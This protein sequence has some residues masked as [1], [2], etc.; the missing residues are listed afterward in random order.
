V[1]PTSL[2][3]IAEQFAVD[4]KIS[5]IEKFGGGLINDTYRINT[6]SKKYAQ[7]ILQRIN[8]EVFLQPEWV[9][10]NLQVLLAHFDKSNNQQTQLT[11]PEIIKTN[12][13]QL[14]YRDDSLRAW[15]AISYIENSQSFEKITKVSDAQQIGSALGEFHRRVSDLPDSLLHDTLPGFHITPGCLTEYE[16]T[17]PA[18]QE[19]PEIHFCREVIAQHQHQANILETAKQQGLLP[20]RVIHGDP[21]LNN[22]LF[23]KTTQRVISII[24][25]DTVKPGLVHYDIGDCLRSCC[26]TNNPVQ[27]DFEICKIILSSYLEQVRPFFSGHDYDY[28]YPAIQLLPFELGLRF[29]TDYLQG[30]RYFKVS[31]LEQNLHRACRQFQLMQSI[32]TQQKKIEDLISSFKKKNR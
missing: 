1:Q 13:T 30:N 17:K 18:K 19:S 15:R 10:E 29:F 21:K 23:C 27:F 24:D 22:L 8:S 11:L 5:A 25:L 12:S 4:G 2:I 20:V 7:F 28:L 14:I 9:M 16:Q 26:Q 6:H 31:E 3:R 32:H